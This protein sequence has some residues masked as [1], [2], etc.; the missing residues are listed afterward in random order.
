MLLTKCPLCAFVLEGTA[1]SQRVCAELRTHYD[2][3]HGKAG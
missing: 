2:A 3:T 1:Q